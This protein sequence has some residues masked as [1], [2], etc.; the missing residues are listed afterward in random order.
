MNDSDVCPRCGGSF[1]CGAHDAVPCA[2]TTIKLDTTTLAELLT[3]YAACLCLNC[4]AE[5]AHEK[6]RPDLAIGRP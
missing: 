6:G 5:L 3:H 2:C 4:L 1:H